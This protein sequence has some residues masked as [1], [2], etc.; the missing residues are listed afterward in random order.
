M[1]QYISQHKQEGIRFSEVES[2]PCAFVD[3]SNKDDPSDGK[4]Q[5]GYLIYWGGPLIT[6]SSKLNHVGIN[7]TYNEYMGLHHC[8]KQLV[9]LRQ[10][11]D[12]IGIGAYCESP[13][14]V[15]ADNRQANTLCAE[16]LVTAGNMY[17]RTGYHYNK[18]AVRDGYACVKYVHTSWN[19]ADALTK[20]LANIKINFFKP[21]L[22]G[23]TPIPDSDTLAGLGLKS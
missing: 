20:G 17:F 8:I 13:T 19:I 21:Y 7:S 2:E 4:T 3:A 16:D 6:K 1:L 5:Y 18:E 23:H 14:P 9:W 10:L 12:E 15:Y 22:H 11:M